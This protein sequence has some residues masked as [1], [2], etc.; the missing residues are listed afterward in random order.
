MPSKMI[1]Y[2]LSQAM[3]GVF[4]GVP[5]VLS[6]M[7]RDGEQFDLPR[8]LREDLAAELRRGGKFQ[9]V[10]SG[11]A[12]AEIRIRV[13]EYGFMVVPGLFRRAMKPI[14]TIETTM[15][16]RDGVQV[17]Q[18]GVV[19]RQRDKQTPT[20]PPERL[21]DRRV[22]TNALHSASKVWAA[23]TAASVK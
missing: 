17:W 5:G 13:R 12:D 7:F 2:G 1:F 8:V 18:S 9:V 21:K 15:V 14:L 19:V 6:T 23:R 22:A 16:R 3:A 11:P 10:E 4:A 20:E